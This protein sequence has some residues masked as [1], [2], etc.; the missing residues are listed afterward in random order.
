MVAHPVVD[1][2]YKLDL[3]D[4]FQK[5]KKKKKEEA[6]LRSLRGVQ[7]CIW[8]ELGEQGGEQKMIMTYN[9]GYY[10]YKMKN[11]KIKQD[12]SYIGGSRER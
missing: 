9:M 3:V 8:E 2:Q 5:G 6:K 4:C 11:K 1:K 10:T 12:I 7:R